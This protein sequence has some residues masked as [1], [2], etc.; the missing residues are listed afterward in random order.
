MR[1]IEAIIGWRSTGRI[2]GAEEGWDGHGQTIWGARK[3]GRETA[4][5]PAQG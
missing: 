4:F 1:K 3:P 5:G 2:I